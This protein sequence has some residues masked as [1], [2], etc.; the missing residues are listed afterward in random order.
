MKLAYSLIPSIWNSTLPDFIAI[1]GM[2]LFRLTILSVYVIQIH[3]RFNFFCGCLSGKVQMHSYGL[4]SVTFYSFY[5][6]NDLFITTAF[7][8]VKKQISTNAFCNV[9]NQDFRYPSLLLDF[10]NLI[11]PKSK[12]THNELKPQ[13]NGY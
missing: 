2:S 13:K 5:Q 3:S 11:S 10:Q 4:V 12:V 6:L 8:C 1:A 7:D 9:L